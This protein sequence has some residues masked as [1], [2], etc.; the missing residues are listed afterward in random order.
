[1]SVAL[2]ISN[3]VNEQERVFYVPIAA[4]RAFEKYWMPVIGELGL[5]RAGWFQCGIEIEKED[6]KFVLEELA[7][8]QNWIVKYADSE[9][10]EQMMGRLENLCKELADILGGARDDIK[11]YIG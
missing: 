10:K 9:R 7:Q 5:K 6:I 1:M 4:E 2:M 3:P 8:I 11:V